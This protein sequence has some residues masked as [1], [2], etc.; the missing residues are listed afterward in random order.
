MTP[1][2]RIR[3]ACLSIGLLTGTS[4][5]SGQQSAPLKD[6]IA[7]HEQKLAEARAKKDMKS[8]AIELTTLGESYREAGNTDKALDDYNQALAIEHSG[9]SRGYEA[10]TKDYIGQVYTD[11]G[12]EQKALDLFNQALPV[13]REIGN[14]L[15]EELTL[16][17]IGRTYSNLAQEDKALDFLNQ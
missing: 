7:Q 6:Q 13:M 5:A 14:R 16:W 10:L 12:Q 4:A 15:G 9:G 2:M 11:M 1:A 3:I 17:N 8:A